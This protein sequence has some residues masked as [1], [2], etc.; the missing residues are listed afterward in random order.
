MRLPEGRQILNCSRSSGYSPETCTFPCH[1]G[2]V[3]C[4]VRPLFQSFPGVGTDLRPFLNFRSVCTVGWVG[5]GS[6]KLLHRKNS[7]ERSD[8]SDTPFDCSQGGGRCEQSHKLPAA[9]ILIQ[10]RAGCVAAV[11][12]GE[13]VSPGCKR[14]GTNSG[15]RGGFTRREQASTTCYAATV[16]YLLRHKC[17]H[18]PLTLRESCFLQPPRP[19][20]GRPPH[21][22]QN[23]RY[24]APP[25]RHATSL[26]ALTRGKWPRS[27]CPS[28]RATC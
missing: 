16:G 26:C 13:P 4:R 2:G 17:W 10:R 8:F 18:P 20:T 7:W 12:R 27:P 19:R 5:S 28:S 9:G 24:L 1:S 21:A 23:Q 25:A 15:A 3:L 6:G 22:P 11:H 14:A